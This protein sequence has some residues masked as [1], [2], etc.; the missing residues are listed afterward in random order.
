VAARRS[1]AVLV[2]GLILALLAEAP[3]EEP[4]TAFV[5]DVKGPIGPATSDFLV[6]GIGKA[7]ERSARVVVLR[8]DTPGGLDTSMREV[9]QAILASPVPV[10]TYVAP[11]GARAA[12]A[13]TYI[14]YASHVAA[15]APGTNLGAATPVQIGGPGGPP[16]MPKSEEGKDDAAKKKNGD[17]KPAADPKRPAPGLSE[18]AVSDAA[19]YLRS[20]AQM[21]GRNVAW[22]EKA[23]RE[24]ESLSAEDARGEGVIEVVATDLND[25]LA[26]IDGRP[27][28]VQ[29]RTLGLDTAGLHIVTVEPDW[30]TELLAIVTNPNVAYVLMLVGVYGLLFEFYSPGLIG[31][32]IIGAICLLLALYAF[33]VLPVSYTGVALVLL[34]LGLMVAET[35]TPSIGALGVGGIAA[36]VIG[37]VML[38]DVE[39]PGFAVAWELV[40]SVA[41]VAAILLLT[42][43]TMLVRVRR[44]KVVAGGEEMIASTGSVL[45]WAGTEGRVRIH[46]EVWRAR[47]TAATEPAALAPGRQVRV[48]EREGLTLIV[49]PEQAKGSPQ[50]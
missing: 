34:G 4:G 29:G 48:K 31:P 20:L 40:G 8:M 38:F 5:L 42:V 24:A 43:L 47:A 28:S 17:E 1:L 9:I 37:S 39:A 12:S 41:L 18:K 15:M 13:G 35:V 45:D 14:L 16:T 19:A 21:R 7:G 46:G 26:K 49:E 22:A 27:V 33:H 50:P 36:F 32:G 2:S 3:A 23:V 6:R 10:V 11:S 25:L 30:R 44:R